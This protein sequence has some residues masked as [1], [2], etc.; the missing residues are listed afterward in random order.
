MPHWILIFLILWPLLSI[1]AGIYIGRII[2][3]M[4]E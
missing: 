2:K 3:R 4:G 1:I